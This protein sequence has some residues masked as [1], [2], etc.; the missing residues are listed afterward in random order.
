[1]GFSRIAI[2]KIYYI[3][4]RCS[5]SARGKTRGKLLTFDY[6]SSYYRYSIVKRD[7]KFTAFTADVEILHEVKSVKNC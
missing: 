1:M 2:L 5:N 4:S 6:I 3:H 7:K